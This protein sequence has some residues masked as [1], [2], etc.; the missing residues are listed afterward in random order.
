MS[1]LCPRRFHTCSVSPRPLHSGLA[2]AKAFMRCATAHTCNSKLMYTTGIF[3]HRLPHHFSPLATLIARSSRHHDLLLLLVP[4]KII[5]HPWCSTPSM[6][7][8][9]GGDADSTNCRRVMISGKGGGNAPKST[10]IST[11]SLI[12]Q[13]SSLQ[14]ANPA[15][16]ELLPWPFAAPNAQARRAGC[17]TADR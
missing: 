7:C 16:P 9:G 2:A 5:L 3:A 11:C 10:A 13:P 12:Q 4:P 8:G 14:R 6:I 1:A 17:D 15:P